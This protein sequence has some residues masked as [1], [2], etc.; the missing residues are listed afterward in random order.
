[1][2]NIDGTPIYVG[3]GLEAAGSTINARAGEITTELQLLKNKLS[4][5]VDAWRESE[6]ATYYQDMQNEWD[7]AANGLFGEDGVL[8]RIA[9]AM[10]VNWNNYSDAEWAN[11]STWRQ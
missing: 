5:L 1:M 10:N 7:L 3:E 6:A 8:G 2:A 9:Q 4:P 11:V